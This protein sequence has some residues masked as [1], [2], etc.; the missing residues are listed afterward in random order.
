[1]REAADEVHVGQPPGGSAG[2][3]DLEQHIKGLS[4]WS[5]AISS[6]I[7]VCNIQVN[8]QSLFYKVNSSAY[9]PPLLLYLPPTNPFPDQNNQNVINK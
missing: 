4:L 5:C 8:L 3:V 6:V 7:R 2:K 1:M 9:H